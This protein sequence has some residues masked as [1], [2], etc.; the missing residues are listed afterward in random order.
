MIRSIKN[1]FKALAGSVFQCGQYFGWDILPRHFYSEIP[2]LRKLRKTTSWKL[3]YSMICVRGLG[4]DSQSAFV[5]S[6]IPPDRRKSL[7]EAGIHRSASKNNGE[8][9]FGPIEAE[10]LHAFVETQKPARIVQI[11]CGV[12]T[13][14]CIAAAEAAK[15]KPDI[16]CIEPYP[17][18]FLKSASER[19]SIRMIPKGVEDLPPDEVVGG[20]SD[21]DLFFVDSSHVLGPAGEVS[22]IILECLPRLTAGVNV[23]FHDVYFPYDYPGNLLNGALFFHHESVLL[24]AFLCGHPRFRVLASLSHLHHAAPEILRECFLNYSPRENDHGLAKSPGHFPSSTY[25][26]VTE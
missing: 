12:S 16:L 20:L 2:D 3:P 5:R 11:G 22:R 24:H 25:L 19:G 9:G 6:L 8:E 13:A 7:A 1:R 10:C 14:I 21:G 26:L 17:N 4:I 18:G 23:H 15:Y